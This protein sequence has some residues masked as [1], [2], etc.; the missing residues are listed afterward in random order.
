MTPRRPPFRRAV[1]PRWFIG[2][3]GLLW[4]VSLLAADGGWVPFR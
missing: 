3:I 4:I 1:L 2:A